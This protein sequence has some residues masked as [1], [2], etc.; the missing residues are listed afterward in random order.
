MF[1]LTLF[2]LPKTWAGHRSIARP[3]R[4]VWGVL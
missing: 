1:E 4:R 2:G 3:G